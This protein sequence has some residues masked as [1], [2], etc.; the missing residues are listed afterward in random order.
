MMVRFV[1]LSLLLLSACTD[2]NAGKFPP[3]AA[4]VNLQIR[5]MAGPTLLP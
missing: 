4:Q 2:P 1:L 5:E 3:N